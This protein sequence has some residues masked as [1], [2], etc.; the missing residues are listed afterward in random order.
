M[1]LK[2]AARHTW[3]GHDDEFETHWRFAHNYKK[4]NPSMYRR[5]IYPS[6]M[7]R[8]WLYLITHPFS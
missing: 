1:T 3:R 4:R 5:T 8:A 6:W 7:R 2:E